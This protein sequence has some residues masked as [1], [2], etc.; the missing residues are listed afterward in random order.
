MDRGSQQRQAGPG[1]VGVGGCLQ[2]C[3]MNG[4]LLEPQAGV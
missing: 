2:L 4:G 3:M 1:K